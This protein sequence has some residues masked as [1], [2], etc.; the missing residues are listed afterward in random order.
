MMSLW[1]SRD[2]S[3]SRL[4]PMLRINLADS[5]AVSSGASL[6][7]LIPRFRAPGC[8]GALGE[9][10]ARTCV[11]VDSQV[12]GSGGGLMGHGSDLVVSS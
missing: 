3:F 1:P 11:C 12:D 5:A 4:L 9:A 10:S 8:L 7:R 6:P 2:A